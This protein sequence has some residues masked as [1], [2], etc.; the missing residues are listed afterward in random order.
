MKAMEIM[1]VYLVT[2]NQAICTMYTLFIMNTT[3]ESN[4][5]WFC[6]HEGNHRAK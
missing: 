2:Q 6:S 5:L 3:I 1:K 4:E